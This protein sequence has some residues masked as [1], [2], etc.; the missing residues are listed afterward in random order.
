MK[1]GKRKTFS[2]PPEPGVLVG[3][4]LLGH[5]YDLFLI[6]PI[7][8]SEQSEF[9]TFVGSSLSPDRAY[10]ELR[11]LWNASCGLF[12][13]MGYGLG[14]L[15]R[16]LAL[17]KPCVSNGLAVCY[18]VK[19]FRT[20]TSD[21]ETTS[22]G[23]LNDNEWLLY[24]LVPS[25]VVLPSL[26]TLVIFGL[27]RPTRWLRSK[28]TKGNNEWLLHKPI[29]WSS[30]IV[31]M[32]LWNTADRHLLQ[33]TVGHKWEKSYA[34]IEYTIQLLLGLA[35]PAALQIIASWRVARL[36]N[37]TIHNYTEKVDESVANTIKEQLSERVI[38]PLFTNNNVVL[39]PE[40]NAYD[41]IDALV[42]GDNVQLLAAMYHVLCWLGVER[43]L[44]GIVPVNFR[45]DIA[46]HDTYYV[47]AHFHYVLSI[48][49]VFALFAGF[50]YWVG[51]SGMLHRI[52]DY[53]AYAGWN[54]LSSSGSYISVVGIC[55]FFVVVAI[56]SSS[57]NNKRC[58]PSPWAVEQNP[59]TPEW[60]VQSPPA[61]H[62]FGELPA[63]KET[64]SS[65]K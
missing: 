64:K 50:H 38:T 43:G 48:G 29:L 6:E 41:V 13:G 22:D 8:F 40:K 4:S 24:R 30:V 26:G 55:H 35:L 12:Q 62:T 19:P 9:H 46:L 11:Q 15:I 53:L 39:P 47:V 51:L 23:Q 21:A 59:T 31:V 32:A 14:E 18:I 1:A 49:A 56:T 2:G 60:M 17:G 5:Q 27:V 54:T 36:R 37:L 44:T 10:V 16:L 45:L 28:V 20:T 63:I 7:L 65:A 58:A 61:F 57:G 42:P 33:A 52:P 25:H 3:G 34:I